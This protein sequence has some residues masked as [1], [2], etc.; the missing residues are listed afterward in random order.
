MPVLLDLVVSE[1]NLAHGSL[2]QLLVEN[3]LTSRILL[4]KMHVLNHLLELLRRQQLSLNVT[5]NQIRLKITHR[6]IQ[7]LQEFSRQIFKITV[8]VH[9]NVKFVLN[10]SRPI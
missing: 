4:D 1:E 7:F 2:T 8:L 5:L 3:K 10:T 9:L 6:V